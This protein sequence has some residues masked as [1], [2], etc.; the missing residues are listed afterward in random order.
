MNHEK[1][2]ALVNYHMNVMST[3]PRRLPYE[4]VFGMR[5]VNYLWMVNI[6]NAFFEVSK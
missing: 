6:V 4:Y 3:I 5:T 1:F 2:F